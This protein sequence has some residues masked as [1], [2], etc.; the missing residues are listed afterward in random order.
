MQ[1]MTEIHRFP[2]S[3]AEAVLPGVGVSPGVGAEAETQTGQM[4]RF[5]V[6]GES[7]LVDILSVREVVRLHELAITPIPNS[8]DYIHGMVNLRGRV[9]TVVDLGHRL[10][11][12]RS[13]S[14]NGRHMIV[15]EIDGRGVGFAVDELGGIVDVPEELIEPFEGERPWTLGIAP[16]NGQLATVLDLQLA[17]G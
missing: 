2:S 1:E 6:G 7:F 10:G 12:T 5:V 3:T 8:H 16:V 15:V 11:L 13:G 14:E 4:I 17:A 9:T